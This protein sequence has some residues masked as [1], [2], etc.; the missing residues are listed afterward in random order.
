MTSPDLIAPPPP[1]DAA[2]TG[3]ITADQFEQIA[4]LPEHADR[5]LELIDG[6][7][8]E[9]MTTEEHGMILVLLS[10][11]FVSYFRTNPLGRASV[12]THHR[13]GEG[14]STVLLPDLA[15]NLANRPIIRRGSVPH[16]PDIA[17][18][19]KSRSNTLKALHDK[20]RF[21]LQHGTR[22]VWIVIPAK[23]L[24]QVFTPTSIDIYDRTDM[25]TGGD[26]LPGFTLAVVDIFADT[27]HIADDAAT[28]PQSPLPE[29]PT[30]QPPAQEG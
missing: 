13:A 19:V 16:M 1:A 18:E 2:P 29:A 6:E 28:Q 10:F 7:I 24:V 27:Q 21:Y 11:Y 15:I 26:V 3:G 4:A 14:D 20:A 12:E 23:Q 5:L 9:K 22:I 8:V 30:G 25:L 17:V